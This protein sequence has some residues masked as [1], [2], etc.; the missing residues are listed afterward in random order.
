MTKEQIEE[1]ILQLIDNAEEMT[2]SD[3]Q[4][5]VEAL[6]MQITRTK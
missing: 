2:R 4:G 1:A 3:V 5:A 6:A